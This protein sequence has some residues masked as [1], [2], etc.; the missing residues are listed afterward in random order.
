MAGNLG[1]KLKPRETFVEGLQGFAA[2]G[3]LI[4][5]YLAHVRPPDAPATSLRD[6]WLLTSA[7]HKTVRRGGVTE[8][9]VVG[10]VFYQTDA[11]AFWQ[12]LPVLA[13]EEVSFGDLRLCAAIMALVRDVPLR[14]RHQGE[15][16]AGFLAGQL[17]AAAKCRS[18]CDLLSLLLAQR[19]E[20]QFELELR[21]LDPVRA[22]QA[23]C[24][25]SETLEGQ[26]M[27]WLRL[28]RLPIRDGNLRATTF[29][30][31]HTRL[32]VPGLIHQVLM[33]GKGMYGLPALLPPVL[34]LLRDQPEQIVVGDRD[35]DLIEGPIPVSALDAHTR[36]G[37]RAIRTWLREAKGLFEYLSAL[38][39]RVRAEKI[40]RTALF[41]VEGSLLDR[42]LTNDRL[43]RLLRDTEDAEL[44]RAGLPAARGPDLY[45]LMRENLPLLNMIR[46]DLW[47]S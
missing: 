8:A 6:R 2:A 16:L 5:R 1:A 20:D 19:G 27:A 12:R 43:D 44:E 21:Q 42:R 22:T 30:S 40:V 23:V 46:R 33:A 29:Q 32:H 15:L 41:H 3:L 11:T 37:Q 18:P 14:R 26:A 45:A 36:I 10:E 38:G 4:D 34:G 47:R 7:L 28:D 35:L 31:L 13:L 24:G 9:M 39:L 17:A 25:E